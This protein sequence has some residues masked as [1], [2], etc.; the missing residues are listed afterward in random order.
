MRQI[1][2]GEDVVY[3]VGEGCQSWNY[4]EHT[5]VQQAQHLGLGMKALTTPQVVPFWGIFS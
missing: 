2:E 1:Y 3:Y 5:D 4:A